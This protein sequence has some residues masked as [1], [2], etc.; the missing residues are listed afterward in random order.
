[1]KTKKLLLTTGLTIIIMLLTT[2]YS[3]AQIPI[4]G[5]AGDHEGFAVWDADGSGPEP[6]GYGHPIP[7]GW[8]T[9]RYYSASKDYDGIDPDPDAAFCHFL[10]NIT[11][12]PLFLQALADNGFTP[13]QVKVKLGLLSVKDDIE[14][15]DWFTID[16]MHYYNRYAAYYFIELNGEPMIS[17]YMN[18][19]NCFVKSIDDFWQGIG[20]FSSPF[21]ASTNS[22]PEV[23]DVAAAF[24][25]D[26]D[27]QELRFIFENV[28]STG[29]FG[30]SGRV[31]GTLFNIVSAYL[32]KGLPELPFV[33]LESDHEGI[34]CWDADGS[35][36]EP[37]NYGHIVNYGGTNYEYSYYYASRDY[38]GIDEDTS[39][40]LCH[41]IEG[42]IGFPNLEIQLAYRGYTLDQFK[43]KS[44]IC[45][46]GNDE[47]GVDWGLNGSIHWWMTY[48]NTVT[49]E[50]DDEPILEYV[51]DT[52]FSFDDLANLGEDWWLYT[53]YVS[54]V[55]ISSGAS[56]DA[57]HVAASFLKDLGGHS[58]KSYMEGHYST[59]FPY[60]NGRD[61]VYQTITTGNLTAKLPAGRLIWENEIK[62]TLFLDQSPYVFMDYCEVPDGEKLFIE[63]GVV[64]KF[65]STEFFVINGCIEAEGTEQLPILFTAYDNSVRWGGMGW[66]QTPVTNDTSKF[67]HCIFE[68]AYGYGEEYGSNCGG[69][70]LINMVE[71]IKISHCLFRYNLVDKFLP[72]NNPGGGAIILSESSIHISH[73]I[74]H[75]NAGSWGGAIAI[76]TESNPVIDNCLFYN[77]ESTYIG[78]GGGAVLVWTDCDP[79]F[80]NCTFAD[81]HAADAGG[82][83]ELEF[84][85]ESTFT[86]CIFWGNTADNGASQISV[87][88]LYPIPSLNVYYSDVEEGLNGITPGFTGDYLYNLDTL[89]EFMGPGEEFPYALSGDSPCINYGTLDPLYLPAGWVC[90]EFCL[91]GNPRVLE[92]VI[93]LGC[94]E[95][96][97]TGYSEFV[98]SK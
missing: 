14:G 53:P 76:S 61:G 65:N 18:Y 84:G 68:Y 19:M 9:A 11:G 88:E 51:I 77:N 64:V 96:L 92:S 79:H 5:L 42:T 81:N 33:G 37:E 31:N 90:P 83:V 27:G 49:I 55:D 70:I 78:G 16:T 40:A 10:D 2:P 50:I 28:I 20:N 48:G 54:V 26:M 45:T 23:Q 36:P 25:A 93:D 47:E 12:F 34:A 58:L 94:Y 63:P 39:A 4:Q 71:K 29:P 69:A 1:M 38:D 80:V 7:W 91:G 6:E 57:Q 59:A 67:K 74:F 56:N 43:A 8:G 15:E 21:D 73:C 98:S 35:G 97:F 44:S 72:T 86:N 17:S 75:D 95:G 13:G 85:G 41:F 52:N 24:L 87:L 46:L 62:D 89:P 3:N 32:E 22:S 60:A 30:G 66:D 82:A